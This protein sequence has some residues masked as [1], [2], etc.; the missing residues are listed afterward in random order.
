MDALR[1]LKVFYPEDTPLRRKLLAHSGNVRDEALRIAAS[2]ACAGMGLDLDLVSAGAWLHDVG[3]CR[4]DA[5]DILCTG[6]EPYIRHGAIG[7]EMLRAY[8]AAHGLDLEPYARICERHTGS[9]LA[10]AE[11]RARGLPLPP[12]DYLPETPEEKLVCL[13][14]KFHSKSGDGRRK[15]LDEVRRGIVRF[16]PGPAARLEALLG[17]FGMA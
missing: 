8:G 3:I 9:G 6:A 11:I 7:A 1:L 10:A 12:G 2:P 17:M 15:T 5:P 13:A 16:G 14:D 4:C